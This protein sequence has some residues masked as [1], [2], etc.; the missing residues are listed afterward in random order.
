MT[1]THRG[2]LGIVLRTYVR[3]HQLSARELV[4]S[5]LP[6]GTWLHPPFHTSHRPKKCMQAMTTSLA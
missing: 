1:T 4:D 5:T 6:R 3:I 2:A